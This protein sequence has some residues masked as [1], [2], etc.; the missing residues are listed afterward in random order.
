MVF[1]A[2]DSEQLRAY[3]DEHLNE[4]IKLLVFSQSVRLPEDPLPIQQELCKDAVEVMTEIAGHSE[5]IDV[6]IAQ[7]DQHRDLA[8]TYNIEQVP[9]IVVLP[10]DETQPDPGLRFYGVPSHYEFL[11]FLDVLSGLSKGVADLQ[12]NT[13]KAL[14]KL[15]HDVH[16]KVFY[17][18]NCALCPMVTHM[19]Y[20]FAL[21]SDKIFTETLDAGEFPQYAQFYGVKGVPYIILNEKTR[22][23]GVRSESDFLKLVQESVSKPCPVLRTA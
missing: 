8:A 10:Q 2:K 7:Y 5:L 18:Q 16:I 15:E 13:L 11:T 1:S 9:A 3:F 17:T 6:E 4:P 22:K 19:A 21:A 14:E 23:M 20:Q 12:I